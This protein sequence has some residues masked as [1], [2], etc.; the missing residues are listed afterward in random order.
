MKIFFNGSQGDIICDW[1]RGRHEFFF[2]PWKKKDL[3]SRYIST[4]TTYLHKA[5]SSPFLIRPMRKWEIIIW[6]YWI[7]HDSKKIP[8]ESEKFWHSNETWYFEKRSWSGLISYTTP[9]EIRIIISVRQMCDI[10]IWSHMY[11]ELYIASKHQSATSSAGSTMVVPQHY[12]YHGDRSK[13]LCFR[14]RGS[15]TIV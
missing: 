5:W 6:N 15:G 12:Q 9:S 8:S 1:F 11:V 3:Y 14:S 10:E 2:Q 4:F 13:L 7:S